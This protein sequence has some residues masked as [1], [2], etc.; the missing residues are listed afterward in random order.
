MKPRHIVI[1]VIFVLINVLVFRT[2]SF[3]KE[4]EKE[5]EI[6]PFIKV[7]E[8]RKVKNEE[9]KF[10]VVGFGT[11]SSF[12]A[13]DLSCEVQGKLIKSNKELK[14]GVKFKKGE[15]L[16]HVNDIE[17]RY[18]LRSRISSF[19]NILAQMLPDI[20]VDFSSEFDKWN[21]YVSSIDLDKRLPDL[22]EWKDDK[23]KIFLSTRNVISE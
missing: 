12:N 10:Q 19:I 17:A 3:N 23:E 5:K 6:K 7:L 9:E 18:N 4:P 8:A 15:L 21:D 11:V 14:P 16:Y 13:V 1:I 20:K 22:P 2:L